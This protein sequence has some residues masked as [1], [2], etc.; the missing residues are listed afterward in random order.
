MP[1]FTEKP[2]FVYMEYLGSMFCTQASQTPTAETDSL[3]D[4]QARQYNWNTI[5]N[6]LCFVDVTLGC[7]RFEGG[8]VFLH[9]D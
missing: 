9:R 2:D 4:L 1:I 7:K 3:F 8:R 6:F 5:F